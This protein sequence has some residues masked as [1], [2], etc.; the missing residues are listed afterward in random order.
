[1]KRFIRGLP[2]TGGSTFRERFRSYIPKL[3][4]ASTKTKKKDKPKRDFSLPPSNIRV[5][6]GDKIGICGIFCNESAYLKEWL[7]FHL[8]V[9][10]NKFVLYDNGSDDDYIDVLNPYI[11]RGLVSLVPWATFAVGLNPQ[12]LAYA[13]AARNCASDMR[14]LIFLDI[15]EFIFSET[16]DNVRPAFTRFEEFDTLAIPRFEFGPNGHKTNPSGLVIESYTSVSLYT[17]PSG[18]G[19]VKSAVRP[20]SVHTIYSP[21][22]IRTMG[23]DLLLEPTHCGRFD[24]RVNHYFSKSE[25]EFEAKLKRGYAW[26]KTEHG[27]SIKAENKMRKL[28]QIVESPSTKYSMDRFISRLKNRMDVPATQTRNT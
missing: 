25:S 20:S 24:L 3:R 13:H 8:M 6:N 10:I 15:D 12:T 4:R 5:V 19:A 28:R 1:M 9:G 27:V 11:A 22:H 14:W 18:R 23:R 26:H 7:E 21:H 16:S 17:K 2:A